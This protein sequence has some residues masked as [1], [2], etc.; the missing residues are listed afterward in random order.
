MKWY[1]CKSMKRNRQRE[2]E[3]R[4]LREQVEPESKLSEDAV[5]YSADG[6]DAERYERT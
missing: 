6:T 2:I 1:T 4:D 5:S 3:Q